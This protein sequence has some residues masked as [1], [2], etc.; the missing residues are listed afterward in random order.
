MTKQL[1]QKF[2]FQYYSFVLALST[3]FTLYVLLKPGINS[4]VYPKN[5]SNSLRKIGSSSLISVKEQ[6]FEKDSSD[7]KLSSV[8]KYS[9]DDGSKIIAS[10][11]RV[12][13][14]DDFKI[15]T[16]GLLTKN[17][18]PIFLKNSMFINTIPPSHSGIVGKDKFIQT[19]VIP[20]STQLADSDFRL[21]ELTKTVEKLNPR[22]K[23]LWDRFLGTAKSIDYSCLV[24]TYKIPSG[25]KQMP[26]R[27]W[28]TIVSKAQAALRAR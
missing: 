1:S 26:P 7:R 17:I 15:E 28:L 2:L 24:L 11:V 4:P 9:Y 13:K 19:C 8:F 12:R 6:K 21:S 5:L 20:G 16:Y 23:N 27:N 10:M 14:K 18:D 3:V 25:L 22:K